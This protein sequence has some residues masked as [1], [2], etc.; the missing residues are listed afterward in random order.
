MTEYSQHPPQPNRPGYVI[1]RTED[2]GV[3]RMLRVCPL[4]G[5]DSDVEV[6]AQGLWDWEHGAFVQVAFPGLTPG[7]R[8]VILNGSHEECF[9]K[10]FAEEDEDEA[11]EA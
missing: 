3:Y 11:P 1:V 9:A 8:E 4:C 2:P 10:A 7:E 5:K 6:P